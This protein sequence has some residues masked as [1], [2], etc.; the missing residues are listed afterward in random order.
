MPTQCHTELRLIHVDITDRR[1]VQTEAA[2]GAAHVPQKRGERKVGLNRN[3]KSRTDAVERAH[4]CVIFPLN[5]EEFS[6]RCSD[7]H[8]ATTMLSRKRAQQYSDD[9]LKATVRCAEP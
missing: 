5:V 7:H 4:I 1:A 2:S 3:V 6:T 9:S 8:K